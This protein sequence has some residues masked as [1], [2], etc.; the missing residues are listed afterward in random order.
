MGYGA[1]I[2]CPGR[3]SAYVLGQ[4]LE[5][6]TEANCLWYLAQRR[7]GVK[8]ECCAKCAGVLYDPGT[9]ARSHRFTGADQLI[10]SPTRGW[11]C[12]EIA[13]FDAGVARSK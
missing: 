12:I 2:A 13:A 9:P 4:F 8:P 10:A 11:S 5:G 3:P 7:A 6:L 1:D